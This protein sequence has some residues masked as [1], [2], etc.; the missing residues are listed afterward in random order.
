MDAAAAG[1]SRVRWGTAVALVIAVIWI[2]VF[3]PVPLVALPLGLLLL[4]LPAAPRWKWIVMGALIWFVGA[5]FPGGPLVELS[6][7]WALLLGA[8][9]LFATLVRPRWAVLAR[10]LLALL[11]AAVG[12]AIWVGITGRWA[13]I[14]AGVQKAM[15][16]ALAL[17]MGALK[18]HGSDAAM[19]AQLGDTAK[20]AVDLQWRLFPSVLALQS[21]AALA[22]AS[23]AIARMSGG[24]A[25][26][27]VLRPLREFR[28]GDQLVWVLVAGL[29]LVVL[30]VGDTGARIGLNALVFMA[31]LYALRG[32]GIFLFLIGRAPSVLS[33]IFTVIAAI[34]LFPLFL[35]AAGF[36]M[37]LGLGDTWL[38][39]RGRVTLAPPA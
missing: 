37:L 4:A 8:G 22:L 20:E 15:L 30:P 18:E 34:F 33:V 1:E 7:D 25:L 13:A 21:L 39:V 16:D 14:D 19:V 23:W 27:F 32:V 26:A 5:T 12:A 11:I 24:K 3:N 2:R 38:D 28:F 17:F 31:G 29:L 36:A 10:A 6:R 35:A 9:F